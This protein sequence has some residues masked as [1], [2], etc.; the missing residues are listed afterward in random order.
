[1][2]YA[3]VADLKSRYK[4]AGEAGLDDAALQTYLDEASQDIDSALAML[5]TVPVANCPR[6]KWLEV[7]MAYAKLLLRPGVGPEVSE[8]EKEAAVLIE[9]ADKKLR[10]YGTGEL[11][12]VDVA[13]AVIP[14]RTDQRRVTS[15]TK[16]YTPIFNLDEPEDWVV[17]QDRLDAIGR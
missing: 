8:L 12:L 16:D 15:N 5:Y 9:R 3:A 7:D 11:P 6:L 1:M 17:D 13:G 2:S 10:Q 14:T 4:R